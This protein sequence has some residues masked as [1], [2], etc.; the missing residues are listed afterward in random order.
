MSNIH[1]FPNVKKVEPIDSLRETMEKMNSLF[2]KLTDM[3]KASTRGSERMS[4][5]EDSISSL[6]IQDGKVFASGPRRIK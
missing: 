4:R 3:T 2:A 6:T 5:F 1:K